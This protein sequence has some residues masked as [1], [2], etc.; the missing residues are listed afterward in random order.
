MGAFEM[1]S[2]TR[3]ALKRRWTPLGHR[4]RCSVKIGYQFGYLSCLICPGCG[5]FVLSAADFDGETVFCPIS[6]GIC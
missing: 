2:G 1:R 6:E 4:P 5:R 3:A